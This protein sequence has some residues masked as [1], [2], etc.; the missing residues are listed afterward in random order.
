M[1]RRILWIFLGVEVL[2]FLMWIVFLLWLASAYD[3]KTWV[4]PEASLIPILVASW[5]GFPYAWIVS[6]LAGTANFFPIN[7]HVP[8]SIA[9]SQ[10]ALWLLVTVLVV[11]ALHRLAR[12]RRHH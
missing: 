4:G 6:D 12:R 10:F 8:V 3:A 2:R 1:W 7:N 5:L 11:W 9:L